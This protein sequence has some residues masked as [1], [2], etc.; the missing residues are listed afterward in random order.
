[1]ALVVK[2]SYILMTRRR[3]G[4]STLFWRFFLGVLHIAPAT[5]TWKISSSKVKDDHVQ[6]SYFFG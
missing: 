2:L 3:F 4:E 1:M 6:F 5:E